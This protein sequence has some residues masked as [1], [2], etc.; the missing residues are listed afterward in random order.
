MKARQARPTIKDVARRAGVSATTVSHAFS[1]NGTVAPATRERVRAVAAELGYRPDALARGLRKSHLG[2]LALVVRPL[3]DMHAD[4]SLHIDY[5]LRMAGAGAL[6]A[7]ENGFG[8][9]LV[10]DPS[11]PESPATALACDGF[12]ISEPLR[13]DPLVSLLEDLSMPFVAIGDIPEHPGG[14]SIVDI[15]ADAIA[16]RVLDALVDSGS[17]RPAVL[18]GEAANAWNLDTE[19]AYRSWARSRGIPAMVVR[20]AESGGVEAGRD[21]VA[22]LL[23]ADGVY[24]LTARH[25]VGVLDG[26]AERGRSVPGDVQVVCGSDAEAARAS[27]PALTAVDLQPELLASL[28]VAQLVARLNGETPAQPQ[29]GA[30]G[31]VRLRA[32]TR[33]GFRVSEPSRI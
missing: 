32:S 23:D 20:R 17:R 26:F 6:S 13:D 11:D 30:T 15:A 29:E 4:Q 24:C 19:R 27:M 3:V 14:A 16:V 25:A 7:H 18:V 10:G 33:A 8:L 28:A 9:M 21:A 5:F 12:I 2:V 31:P 1:G 22:E